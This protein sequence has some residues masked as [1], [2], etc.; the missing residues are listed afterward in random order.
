ML[1]RILVPLDELNEAP[2]TRL[3][4]SFS[5]SSAKQLNSRLLVYSHRPADL[6]GAVDVDALLCLTWAAVF[7]K[8]RAPPQA[9]RI[10]H[11]RFEILPILWCR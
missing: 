11:D 4:R 1:L 10:P 3:M 9:L 6:I 2:L 7:L 8:G 5:Q